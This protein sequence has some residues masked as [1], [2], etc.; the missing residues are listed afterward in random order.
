M[1]VDNSS[2]FCSDEGHAASSVEGERPRTIC[3]AR[4]LVPAAPLVTVSKKFSGENYDALT[5][6]ESLAIASVS[7]LR[8]GRLFDLCAGGGS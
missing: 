5:S 3:S 8:C 1:G 6:V 4:H 7:A 2:H